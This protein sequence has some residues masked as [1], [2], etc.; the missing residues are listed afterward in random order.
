MMNAFTESFKSNRKRMGFTQR[1]VATALGVS[2]TAVYMWESGR[3]TPTM[4]NL[5]ALEKL[6]QMGQGQLLVPC[7]YSETVAV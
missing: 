4:G 3:S 6:F 5:V 1:Y 2:Q 7:A